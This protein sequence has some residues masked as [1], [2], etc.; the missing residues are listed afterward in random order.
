MS[1]QDLTAQIQQDL[2]DA[3]MLLEKSGG[4]DE[5]KKYRKAA[6]IILIKTLHLDPENEKARALLQY[7]RSVPAE[8]AREDDAFVVAPAQTVPPREPVKKEKKRSSVKLPVVLIAMVALGAGLLRIVQSHRVN[9]STL[10]APPAQAQRV[11]QPDLLP[12]KT[13]TPS[14]TEEIMDV[15]PPAADPQR[16]AT[17]QILVTAV[18]PPPL[19]I[20]TAVGKLAVSSSVAAEIYAGDRWVGSTPTT[21]QLPAGIQTLEY[22][23]EDLRTVITHEIKPDETVAASITFQIT[24]LINAKPWAQ[25]FLDGPQRRP[26]GQ[27]PLSGATVPVGGVLVFENPNFT[28]KTYRIREQDKTIQVN[29]P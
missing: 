15:S 26:L 1:K 11:P 3:R 4:H 13:D 7:A 14:P 2:N 12:A 17:N 27:T 28:P 8:R 29:F 25:V 6:E 21:L 9:P 20:S 24:V 22:R 16:R 10:A 19:A 5:K 18:P 23:H